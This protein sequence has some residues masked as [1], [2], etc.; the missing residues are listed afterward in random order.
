MNV[1]ISSGGRRVALV[2]CFR[3][4]LAE[5]GIQGRVIAMDATPYC[6][7]AHFADAFY[8]VPYC[9]DPEF[10][11]LVMQ[12]CER[13]RID[14]IVPTIDYEL[15]VYAAVQE[16][17][18]ARGTTIA[19]S[20]QETIAITRNKTLTQ[21]WLSDHGFSAPRQS[22]P[23]DVLAHSSEWNLPLILKPNGGSASVGLHV[24]HSF[25]ALAAHSK[26]KDALIVQELITGQ[27]HTVNVFVNG[28]GKCVCAV[29]HRRLAVRCG[30]VSKAMTVKNLALMQT[31]TRLVEALPSAFGA[32]NVQCFVTPQN[33]IRIIE[34]NARFGGGY[35][36]AHMAGSKIT[37]WLIED[38]LGSGPQVPY[39]DWTD[40]LLML[41]YDEAVYLRTSDCDA[42]ELSESSWS[43]A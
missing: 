2:N 29:P 19:V 38:T 11:R 15:S 24:L 25:E 40:G 20:S 23:D 31:A 17:F 1:L 10:I 9:S 42:R 21:S 18:R 33:D 4:S 8:T 43:P 16:D 22:T 28:R 30:E 5:M 36:L 6:S 14:L 41:R 32:L 37:R 34:I 39:E 13:E 26:G 7:I 27:E 3:E 35:P 12:I